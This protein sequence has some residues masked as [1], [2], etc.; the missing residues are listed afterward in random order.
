MGVSSIH[1]SLTVFM[2]LMFVCSVFLVTVPN[3]VHV[4]GAT[5][6]NS[7]IDTDTTWNKANSPYT[8][9]TT[10]QV[11][12]NAKLTI[13]PGVVINC[14]PSVNTMFWVGGNITAIGTPSEKIV[15]DGG[16]HSSFFFPAP[17]VM[18]SFSEFDYCTIRNGNSFWAYSDTGHGYFNL[19]H[20]SLVNLFGYSLLAYPE[21]DVNIRYNVFKAAA[22]FNVGNN[23]GSIYFVNNLFEDNHGYFLMDNWASYSPSQTVIQNNSFVNVYGTI[24]KLDPGCSYAAMDARQNY[25]GTNNTTTIASMIFD[26]TDDVTC[27]TVIPFENILQEPDPNTPSGIYLTITPSDKITATGS[28]LIGNITVT[29]YD[30][31]DN[32]KTD[33]TGSVYF[34]STDTQAVLPYMASE[35]YT[36]TLAD[37]GIHVFPGSGFTLKT[38]GNQ[39]ISV[40]DAFAKV[41]ATSNPILVEPKLVI[42]EGG[43]QIITAGQMS[44][45][46]T[47][48]MQNYDGTPVITNS[49]VSVALHSTSTGGTFYYLGPIVS[50]DI[51]NGT[52]SAVFNYSDWMVGTPSLIASYDGL[53]VTTQFRIEGYTAVF[54][55]TG[56]SSGNSWS[57]TF[58]GIQ[59]FSTTDTVR[60]TG[61][62]ATSYLWSVSAPVSGIQ[63]TV[64]PQYG[65]ATMSS[66]YSEAVTFSPIP[67]PSPTPIQ[68]PTPLTTASPTPTLTP[69]STQQ[70]TGT[71]TPTLTPT[72]TPT[73]MTTAPTPSSSVPEF[74]SL[75]LILLTLAS[76]AIFVVFLK[77]KPKIHN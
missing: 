5:D 44:T 48:Q 65:T 74:P 64:S 60:I 50:L 62:S 43:N 75:T 19:T 35:N 41:N 32:I 36:F 38:L 77:K 34:T 2:L 56:L 52:D 31:S 27:G 53:S 16:G 51:V 54:S 68:T 14:A 47:I 4:Q 9:T 42:I 3:L 40:T 6:A 45:P 73:N 66:D 11:M 72:E 76:I 7:V 69:L 58:G 18:N 26:Q 12:P 55:E 24:L 28:S 22:G 70:P 30:V 1:K 57:V 17:N 15:F 71:S 21:R 63:Y 37:S 67:T 59:Y 8:I 20:S 49:T 33:Y 10:V 39:T 61:L 23:L 13:E 46:V 25:W 29:A